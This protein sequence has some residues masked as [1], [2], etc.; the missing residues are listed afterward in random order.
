MAGSRLTKELN[1]PLAA[2]VLVAGAFL[3]GLGGQIYSTFVNSN[4]MRRRAAEILVESETILHAAR[5]TLE[6]SRQSPFDICSEDDLTYQRKLLFN[7]TYIRDIGRYADNK[8]ICTIVLGRIATPRHRTQGQIED[9]SGFFA[10]NEGELATPETSGFV[11]G[12]EPTNLVVDTAILRRF[13]ANSYDFVV[14]LYDRTLSQHATVFASNRLAAP[15]VSQENEDGYTS[16]SSSRRVCVTVRPITTRNGWY[17]YPSSWIGPVIGVLLAIIATL[18]H[19]S[20]KMQRQTLLSKLRIAISSR[21]LTLVYQ[22]IVSVSTG[23]IVA[24]EALLRWEITDGD[25]VPPD[26]FIKKAEDAGII[27]EITHYVVDMVIQEMGE[28]IRTFKCC[29][30]NINMS[31]QNLE[32]DEFIEKFRRQLECARIPA[33]QIGVELT[34]STPLP[35]E[36]VADAIRLLRETGHEIY[37]DDFGT[38]YSNLSYLSQSDIGTI[39]VDKSFI[40]TFSNQSGVPCLVPDIISIAKQHGVKVVIEGVETA[41]QATFLESLDDDLFGQGWF[42]G[43]PTQ[44]AIAAKLYCG[45]MI[46]QP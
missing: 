39:K 33:N 18:A 21:Q 42:Y 45:Q 30:V 1:I 41:E 32:S 25:F 16:C 31:G 6:K 24:F 10:Y 9:G 40:R 27:N 4:E 29:R 35:F 12:K 22:P 36:K 8:L 38:G 28:L 46:A 17:E 19:L 34:E 26:V 11:L 2:A 7:T 43:K 5:L 3:G 15:S 37:V 20:L 44:A 14:L 13:Q 23:Q